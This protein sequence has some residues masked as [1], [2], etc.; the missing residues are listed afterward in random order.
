MLSRIATSAIFVLAL[1]P[2]L[3]AQADA[4]DRDEQID[5]NWSKLKV[6]VATDRR[7]YFPGELVTIT[8]TVENPTSQALEIPK[9]FINRTGVL[10]YL[11]MGNRMAAHLSQE[12]GPM[13]PGPYVIPPP[14][15]SEPA[16]ATA[17][18]KPGE[19]MTKELH[20]YDRQLTDEGQVLA[21]G[22][23]SNWPGEFRI[24]YWTGQADFRVVMPVFEGMVRITSTE[25]KDQRPRFRDVNGASVYAFALAEGGKHFLCLDREPYAGK[26]DVPRTDSDR[27][28]IRDEFHLNRY[29]RIA[30]SDAPFVSLK[31]EADAIGNILL[32]WGE[33]GEGHLFIDHSQLLSGTEM[34]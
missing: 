23:A 31:G 12:Y 30:E 11:E 1:C 6:T 15:G 29:S 33:A 18:M 16:P 17:I 26:V 21:G 7:E 13:G 4:P 9:P 22:A 2:P 32:T 3:V 27:R 8:I 20:S 5:T 25:W 19:V 24:T 10:S 34:Y 14:I 28:L